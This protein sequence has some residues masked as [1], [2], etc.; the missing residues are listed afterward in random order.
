M[1]FTQDEIQV[2]G[3]RIEALYQPENALDKLMT[4]QLFPSHSAKP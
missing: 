3:K 4:E 1:K 2:I